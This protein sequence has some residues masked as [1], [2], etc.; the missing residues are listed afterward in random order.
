VK[1]VAALLLTTLFAVNPKTKFQSPIESA[2]REMV[3]NFASSRFDAA[4]KDF[5]DDLRPIVTPAV[6]AEVKGSLDHTVGSFYL[7]K[8][9]HQGHRESFRTIE[10]LARYE[11]GTV[12][13][14]V[15]FD[16]LDKIGSVYFNPILNP[17]V[18]PALEAIAR[19]VLTN[20][21]AGHFDDAVK[22]FNAEMSAQL[23]PASMAGL[24]QSITGI[25]GTFR[26][27]TE[28]HQSADNSY[29]VI[30][31]ILAYTNGPVDFRVAFDARNR[32][33]AL[34]ISPA[35]KE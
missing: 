30:D 24:S 31:L 12:S 16:Q 26:S 29:K 5:N 10:L 34:R 2:A 22:P 3:T 17:A 4:T 1:I 32:V 9:A 20:F 21:T 14:V 6:L 25:F 23:T 8:E 18:D 19:D 7:V 15:V 11:K 28:V 35:K 13:I 27:V 33:A